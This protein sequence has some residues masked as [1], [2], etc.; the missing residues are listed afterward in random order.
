MIEPS[1][2]VNDAVAVFDESD[3]YPAYAASSVSVGV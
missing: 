3:A 1:D 2:I